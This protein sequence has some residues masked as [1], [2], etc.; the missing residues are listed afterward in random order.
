MNDN[1]LIG[2]II[3]ALKTG[4]TAAGLSSVIV[5]QG[6]QP[7]QQGT[8]SGPTIYLHKITVERYGFLK[9]SN[10]FNATTGVTTH[11]EVQKLIT[12]YQLNATAIQD[13]SNT[14]ALTA[15][16]YLETAVAILNSDAARIFLQSNE[17]QV[18]RIKNG[19][20]SYF[21][22]DKDRFESDPSYDCSFIHSLVRTSITPSTNV[23]KAGIYPV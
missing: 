7:T 13:P 2:F 16:D 8:P 11:T 12:G 3:S 1:L 4:F 19:R 14:T 20:Q 21:E 5:K 9:R 10:S 23:T 17:I 15:G 18:E 22:D 6:Y